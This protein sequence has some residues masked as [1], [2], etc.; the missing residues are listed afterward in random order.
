MIGKMIVVCCVFSH[1]N[2]N[3]H[4]GCRGNTTWALAQWQHLVAS[5]EATLAFHRVIMIMLYRPGG[6]VI[7]IAI[8]LVTFVY[9]VD[10]SAARKIIISPSFLLFS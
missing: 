9:I 2:D 1:T 10:N 5:C 7:K 8:K 4:G 6:M 3:N